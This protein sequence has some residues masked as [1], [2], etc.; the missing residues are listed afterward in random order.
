VLIVIAFWIVALA[1]VGCAAVPGSPCAG[2][3]FCIN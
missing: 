3:F 1:L 2:S